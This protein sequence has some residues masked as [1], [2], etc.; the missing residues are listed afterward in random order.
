MKMKSLGMIL[1]ALV[2]PAGL[3]AQPHTPSSLQQEHVNEQQPGMTHQPM[4]KQCQMLMNKHQE[5]MSQMKALDSRLDEKVAAMNAARGK[6]KV[7]AMADVINELVTQRRKMRQ[8][9]MMQM[10]MMRHMMD[11][12]RMEEGVASLSTCPM[13]KEMMHMMEGKEKG[14]RQNDNK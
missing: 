1:I 9:M 10:G 14:D 7:D 6:K 2:I 13:M 11:H 8:Q 3:F 12:L 5:M 4:M